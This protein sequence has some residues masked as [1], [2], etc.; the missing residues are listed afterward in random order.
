M[1]TFLI[2]AKVIIDRIIDRIQ[3]KKNTLSEKENLSISY[4]QIFFKVYFWG[5]KKIVG[6]VVVIAIFTD[7]VK[8]NIFYILSA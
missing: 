4:K 8:I 3:L 2:F 5:K 1:P 7:F 6:R